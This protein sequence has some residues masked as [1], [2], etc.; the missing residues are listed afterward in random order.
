MAG[1]R[2]FGTIQSAFDFI[3]DLCGWVRSH[4]FNDTESNEVPQR[5]YD[6]TQVPSQYL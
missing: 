1:R 2:F 5:D 4:A 3:L 6:A